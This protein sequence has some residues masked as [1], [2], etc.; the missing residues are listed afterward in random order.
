MSEFLDNAR[1]KRRKWDVVIIDPPA[2][3]PSEASVTR[4]I[5]AYRK[6]AFNGAAVTGLGGLLALASCSSH[7]NEATFLEAC[8][9]GISEAHRRAT[10]LAIHSQPADHPTPLAMPEFRYLKFALMRVE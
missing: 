2:F 9:E 4:A 5:S 7:I 3:A 6:L 8:E 10:L 1:L